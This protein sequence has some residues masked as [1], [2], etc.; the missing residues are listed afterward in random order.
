[1]EPRPC[2]IQSYRPLRIAQKC[3]LAR[4][5]DAHWQ[6]RSGAENAQVA[7][8]LAATGASGCLGRV[9]IEAPT[10]IGHPADIAK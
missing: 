6:E 1:M 2:S 9:L 8:L 10:Q 4:F 3:L 5:A 7:F